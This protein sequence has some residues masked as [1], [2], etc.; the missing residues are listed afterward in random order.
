M[1]ALVE[2]IK[3]QYNKNPSEIWWWFVAISPAS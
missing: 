1:N 2:L 3:E